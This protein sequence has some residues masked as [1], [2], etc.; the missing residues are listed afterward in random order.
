M[1]V[2]TFLGHTFELTSGCSSPNP[3]LCREYKAK[4]IS[5]LHTCDMKMWICIDNKEWYRIER[6]IEFFE[7]AE[8]AETEDE[9]FGFL[10]TLSNDF[11]VKRMVEKGVLPE[12]PQ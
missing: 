2:F 6:P 11:G 8:L 12:Q 10:E 3:G 7:Y 4:G 9:L 5:Y 1:R